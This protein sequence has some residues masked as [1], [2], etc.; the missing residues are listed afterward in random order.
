[1]EVGK[2]IV[3]QSPTSSEKQRLTK[4]GGTLIAQQELNGA[5]AISYVDK[6]T[7]KGACL[8]IFRRGELTEDA[9]FANYLQAKIAA[10]WA[11]SPAIGGYNEA[12]IHP[13]EQ[14]VYFAT[15]EDWLFQ[16]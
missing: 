15:A 4:S 5:Q 6:A 16:I 8:V 1:M 14:D 7:T 2:A 11:I 3:D 13:S 10:T 9:V 12:S